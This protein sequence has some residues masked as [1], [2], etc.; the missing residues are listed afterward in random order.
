MTKPAA[1][2]LFA[3]W[4]KA[5]FRTAASYANKYGHAPK[6]V[7]FWLNGKATPNEPTRK[8]IEHITGGAVPAVSWIAQKETDRGE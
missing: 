5:D 2:E 6:T 4:L 7:Q 3:A 1:P 8:R